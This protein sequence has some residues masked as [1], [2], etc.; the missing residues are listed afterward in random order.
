MQMYHLL[1]YKLLADN[2]ESVGT[3]FLK[4]S[5]VT[6]GHFVSCFAFVKVCSNLPST[7]AHT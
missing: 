1:R 2:M 6:S 7:F 4:T 3:S 5:K